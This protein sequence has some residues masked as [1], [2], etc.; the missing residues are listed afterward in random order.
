MILKAFK[1]V[2][3]YGSV[4][5][6]GLAVGVGSTWTFARNPDPLKGHVIQVVPYP[7][8]LKSY[9]Q[10]GGIK[11][12]PGQPMILVFQDSKDALDSL[13]TTNMKALAFG[14]VLTSKRGYFYMQP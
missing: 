8:A 7:V 11:P 4:L 5:A 2:V 13:G 10:F 14:D 9:D 6:L 12:K 1:S 3:K